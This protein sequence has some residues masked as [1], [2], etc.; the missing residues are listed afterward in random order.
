M[1]FRGSSPSSVLMV[2]VRLFSTE[3]THPTKH[4]CRHKIEFATERIS[5]VHAALVDLRA[6]PEAAEIERTP[7]VPIRRSVQRHFVICL[8]CGFRGRTLRRH[9]RSRHGL[10]VDDI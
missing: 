1:C 2:E 9:L 5:T 3:A 6:S 8:D 10:T 4:P 7:A